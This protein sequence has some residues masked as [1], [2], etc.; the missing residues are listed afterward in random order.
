M[1]TGVV[2]LKE[3]GLFPQNLFIIRNNF[4]SVDLRC[5]QNEQ[6]PLLF[7]ELTFRINAKYFILV[8]IFTDF[9]K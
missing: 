8:I 1:Y 6:N 4:F 9:T 5:S 7:L 3:N 2:D